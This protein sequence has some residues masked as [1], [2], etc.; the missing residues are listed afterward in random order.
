MNSS[1]DLSSNTARYVSAYREIL[2]DMVAGMESVRATNSISGDFIARMLPHHRAAVEMSREVLKYTTDLTLQRIAENIIREQTES[3]RQLTAARGR[4]SRTVNAAGNAD[5]YERQVSRIMA[6]MFRRME[7]ARVTNSIDCD[8]IRE[9]IPHHEGAIAMSRAALG[10]SL[11]PSLTPILESI[12]TNQ[13]RGVRNL[14]EL[15][16][17]ICR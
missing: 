1:C 12:I 2:S 15:G 13:A 6:E 7:G 4:C 11:C 17:V 14:R 3:I 10:Y 16:A 5:R 9:M 8:F